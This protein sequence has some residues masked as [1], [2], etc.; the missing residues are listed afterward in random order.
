MCSSAWHPSGPHSNGYSL[1]R[2]IVDDQ[3][4]APDDLVDLLL[5]PTRIYVRAVRPVLGLARGLCH[6]TGGGFVDNLPR[7]FGEHLAAGPGPSTH[8]RDRSCSTS[9]N[10]R[11]GIDEVE[12]LRTFNLGIGFVVCAARTRRPPPFSRRCARPTNRDNVIGRIVSNGSAPKRGQ[13]V[14]SKSGALLG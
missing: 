6:I 9:F 14:V 7:M 1:I 2:R 8:G 3:G 12:M 5:V 13:L 10:R 4:G 11:G